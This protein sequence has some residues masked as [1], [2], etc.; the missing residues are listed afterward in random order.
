[1]LAAVSAALSFL[2]ILM[3]QPPKPPPINLAPMISFFSAA[4]AV[5]RLRCTTHLDG[6][7]AIHCRGAVFAELAKQYPNAKFGIGEVGT[8]KAANKEA[9]IRKYYSMA[10][11][12]SNWVGGQ[13]W[14]YFKQDA[15]PKTKPLWSVF[16]DVMQAN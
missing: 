7:T 6:G 4:A 14:W 10:A 5:F 9:L 15:V 11:P 12:V 1:M 13:F 2:I 8:E 3:V 16:R